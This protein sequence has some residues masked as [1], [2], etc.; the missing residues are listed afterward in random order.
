MNYFDWNKVFSYKAD[1]TMVITERGLG[2]TY[3]LRKQFVRDFLKDGSRFVEFVRYKNEI[4]FITNGYFSKLEE[5]DEFPDYCFKTDAQRAYIAPRPEDGGRPAKDE[6]QV[7]GYFIALSTVQTVKKMTFAKV[8]RMVLDEAVIDKRVNQYSRYL[9]NEYEILTNAVDSV[10]RERGDKEDRVKP[11]LYLLGNACDM[12]NPYFISY[13][14]NRIPQRGFTW[15]ANKTFLLCYPRNAEY[16][17]TKAK[18][19]LAGR[20]AART[21]QRYSA[22]NNEFATGDDRLI[23]PKEHDADLQWGVK[24]K[25][26]VT[27]IWRSKSTQLYYLCDGMPKNSGRPLYVLTAEDESID[28]RTAKRTENRFILLKDLYYYQ[29]LRYESE[30]VRLRF[31][32]FMKVFGI[33]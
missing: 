25:G 8:R 20:M 21:Y 2:K 17:E 22:L 24:W 5:N 4:A 1:I 33:S 11:R 29:M 30:G 26:R 10:T 28:T 13:G 3:G 23:E 19:T 31:F 14:V 27:S 6:W 18:N 32:D 15:W 12:L 16:A 7:L 9:K